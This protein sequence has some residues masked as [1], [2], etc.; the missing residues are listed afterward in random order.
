MFE[1][2]GCHTINEFLDFVKL[3]VERKPSMC[4]DYNIPRFCTKFSME[5]EHVLYLPR[6]GHEGCPKEGCLGIVPCREV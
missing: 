1:I 4:L 2:V 3:Q 5:E 6:K